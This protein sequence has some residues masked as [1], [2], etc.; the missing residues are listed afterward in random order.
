MLQVSTEFVG[1]V[2]MSIF[3]ELTVAKSE[4]Q[5]LSVIIFLTKSDF[6]KFCQI[7]YTC[8]C[9]FGERC[10]MQLCR[11]IPKEGGWDT[12]VGRSRS[13]K[14]NCKILIENTLAVK[15]SQKNWQKVNLV[16]S[17]QWKNSFNN[18]GLNAFGKIKN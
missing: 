9:I 13:I 16:N 7:F 10:T 1:L 14:P 4:F 2:K 5:T 18:Y 11:H 12:G 17:L 15:A 8:K 3:D 6:T